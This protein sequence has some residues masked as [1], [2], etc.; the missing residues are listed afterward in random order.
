VCYPLASQYKLL[1]LSYVSLIMQHERLPGHLDTYAYLRKLSA[2]IAGQDDRQ[3]DAPGY[4][5]R[6]AVQR[7]EGSV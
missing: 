2:K 6:L 5:T 3:I 1:T 4:A 7:Q